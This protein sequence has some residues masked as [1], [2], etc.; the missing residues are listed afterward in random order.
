LTQPSLQQL[1][2]LISDNFADWVINAPHEYKQDGFIID[3]KPIIVTSRY[4]QNQEMT[5][6]QPAEAESWRTKRDFQHVHY[7]SVAIATHFRY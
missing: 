1:D 6:D 5:L 4:G 2:Q 7:M 3:R